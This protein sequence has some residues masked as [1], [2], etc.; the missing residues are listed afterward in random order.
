M[1][2]VFELRG[3]QGLMVFEPHPKVLLQ[4]DQVLLVD[5]SYRWNLHD[6]SFCLKVMKQR[7]EMLMGM[8][9]AQ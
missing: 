4:L 9:F 1:T 2:Q 6:P 5:P 3:R 7:D 8:V